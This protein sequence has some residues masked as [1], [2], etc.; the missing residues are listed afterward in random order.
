MENVV[1]KNIYSLN[2]KEMAPSWVAISALIVFALLFSFS[3]LLSPFWNDHDTSSNLLPIIHFKHSIPDQ[4]TLPVFT[5]LWYGGRAQWA[6][7]LWIF[8]Y[9][10]ST[11]VWLITPLDW[12]TWIVFLGHLI[13]SLFATSKLATRFLESELESVSGLIILASPIFRH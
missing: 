13:L 6:N 9:L 4:H 8:L 3:A 11:I 7:P 1:K 5:D 10:P 12:V 2:Q